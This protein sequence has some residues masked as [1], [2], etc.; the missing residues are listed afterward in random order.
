MGC[1]VGFW[2]LEHW[3]CEGLG[4]GLCLQMGDKLCTKGG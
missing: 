4:V 2:G 3:G 1:S